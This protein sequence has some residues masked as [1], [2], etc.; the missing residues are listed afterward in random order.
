MKFLKS[1]MPIWAT[2][3]MFTASMGPSTAYASDGNQYCE[4]ADHKAMDFWLGHWEARDKSGRKL[5]LQLVEKIERSCVLQE[6]WR[7][8]TEEDG[9]GTSLSIYDAK[10]KLWNHTWMSVRGNL[11]SLDGGWDGEAMVMTGYYINREG[12]REFHRTKWKP[13][14]DQRVYQLWDVSTDG[15]ATWQVIHEAWLTRTNQEILK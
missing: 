2:L 8:E 13:L 7:G 9:G 5:G 1:T 3:A 12:R 4:T 10:R 14:A 6:W 11:L 15:G